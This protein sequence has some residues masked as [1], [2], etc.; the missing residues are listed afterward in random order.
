METRSDPGLATDVPPSA[1]APVLEQLHEATNAI[2]QANRRRESELELLERTLSTSTASTSPAARQAVE[3]MT[4]VRADHL[5]DLSHLQRALRA[6]AEAKRLAAEAARALEVGHA[7]MNGIEEELAAARAEMASQAEELTTQAIEIAELQRLLEEK[8]RES[9][10]LADLMGVL[11][12]EPSTLPAP[13]AAE[14]AVQE[15]PP[16][17]ALSTADVPTVE[18]PN[19]VVQDLVDEFTGFDLS[20]REDYPASTPGSETAPHLEDERE[21]SSQ[22]QLT[23]DWG[24]LLESGEGEAVMTWTGPAN[25]SPGAASIPPFADVTVQGATTAHAAVEASA[26][27]QSAQAPQPEEAVGSTSAPL[28]AGTATVPSTRSQIPSAGPAQHE[29]DAQLQAYLRAF[30]QGSQE[31]KEASFRAK[32][33]V[34]QFNCSTP[35]ESKLVSALQ[36]QPRSPSELAAEIGLEVG[37]VRQMLEVYRVRGLVERGA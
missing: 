6:L 22:E 13:P 18:L 31:R 8:T 32:A 7:G 24:T 28:A 30:G 3:R 37:L 25:A 9:A 21:P 19:G 20:P 17:P 23:R 1:L 27:S 36:R 5:E 34:E 2:E 35:D 12:G 29:V 4:R 15:E 11:A 33:P 26:A 10:E 16:A 14:V